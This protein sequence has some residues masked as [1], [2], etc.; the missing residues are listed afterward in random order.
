LKKS[1][2]G[3]R[4]TMRNNTALYNVTS[5]SVWGSSVTFLLGGV[6]SMMALITFVIIVLA[7]SYLR[8]SSAQNS[9]GNIML[10]EETRESGAENGD[11]N[12]TKKNIMLSEGPRE[13]H[14][15][16]VVIMAGDVMPTFIA[17]PTSGFTL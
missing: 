10:S 12:E 13:E 14:G 16:V 5:P 6:G 7:C 2:C 3:G 11:E 15:K 9:E 8:D 4:G 1:G 17:N